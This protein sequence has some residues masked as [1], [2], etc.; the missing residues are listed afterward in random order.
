MEIN[1]DIMEAGGNIEDI[2]P[3]ENEN[4]E[5]MKKCVRQIS[6]LFAVGNIEE[7]KVCLIRLKYFANIDDKIKQIYRDQM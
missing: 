3:I 5:K 1:E 6:D 4:A 2:E 7:A